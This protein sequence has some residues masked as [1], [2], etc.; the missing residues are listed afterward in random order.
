MSVDPLITVTIMN[1][2]LIDHVPAKWFWVI[3]LYE[4]LKDH[5][6]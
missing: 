1:I 4:G 5:T 2:L 6:I 3:F